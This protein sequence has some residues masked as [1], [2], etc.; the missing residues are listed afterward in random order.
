MMSF[1]GKILQI[2]G[3]KITDNFP[4]LNKSVIV[5]APHTSYWDGF[6]GKLF[7]MQLGINY[8]FSS[9]VLA[10]IEAEKNLLNKPVFR[11]GLEYHTNEV[12][13]LRAGIGTSPSLA[14]F[15]IGIKKDAYQFDIAASY[16]QVL[17]FS[18]EISFQYTVGKKKE[19]SSKNE[20]KKIEF[21]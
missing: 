20:H 15:G 14:S 4:N 6:Y 17:G 1:S 5:F 8:K 11:A 2:L 10:T 7:F 13:Y 18:P 3:W 19:T 21:E 16:H 9:Q 12:L